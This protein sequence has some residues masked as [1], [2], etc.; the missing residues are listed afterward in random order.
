MVKSEILKAGCV[1]ELE[2]INLNSCGAI[3]YIKE[4][5][6][7]LKSYFNCN[8]SDIKI[9]DNILAS[10]SKLNNLN[11]IVI[12]IKDYVQIILDQNLE[13]LYS[14]IKKRGAWKELERE[15]AQQT[16]YKIYITLSRNK[17]FII[18]KEYI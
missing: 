3:K 5:K 11:C 14:Y 1:E 16:L 13:I 12:D 15:Q 4:G 10:K 7:L 6:E 9:L 8:S 2:Q 17:N 18:K